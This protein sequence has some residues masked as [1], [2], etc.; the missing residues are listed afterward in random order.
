MKI[1]VITVNQQKQV[2]QEF[3]ILD[4]SGKH[5]FKTAWLMES[6]YLHTS[7]CINR[8]GVGVGVEVGSAFAGFLQANAKL[9]QPRLIKTRAEILLLNAPIKVMQ[10]L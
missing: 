6:K 9:R 4:Q 1:A 8:V 2:I 10:P 3:F 5:C 7:N